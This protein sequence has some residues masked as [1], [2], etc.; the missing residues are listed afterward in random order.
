MALPNPFPEVNFTISSNGITIKS[1]YL[2][3]PR[4]VPF[5]KPGRLPFL[6]FNQSVDKYGL[7]I[8]CDRFEYAQF[9]HFDTT[10][11][12]AALKSLTI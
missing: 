9:I 8:T 5:V 1:D 12:I 7:T 4:F 6:Y 10:P 11:E 2:D 3:G